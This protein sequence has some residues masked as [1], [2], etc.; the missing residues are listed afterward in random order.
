MRT[1][2]ISGRLVKAAVLHIA[3]AQT[4][5]RIRQHIAAARLPQTDVG[6]EALLGGGIVVAVEV[7]V[8]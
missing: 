6:K 4:V 3:V 8:A 7:D 5:E 2:I 1:C